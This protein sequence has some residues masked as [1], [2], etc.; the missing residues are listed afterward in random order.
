[1]TRKE[2]TKIVM[3]YPTSN[4][5]GFT[6][7]EQALLLMTHF[8]GIKLDRY[9]NSMLGSTKALIGNQGITYHSDIITGIMCGL[10]DR[11]IKTEEWD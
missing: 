10:E 9:Y 1:M 3:E 5:I 4:E 6:S 8:D 7:V 11:D 2:V